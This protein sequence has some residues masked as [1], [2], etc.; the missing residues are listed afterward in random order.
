M[1]SL[2][3]R[4]C[5]AT[6]LLTLAT[7]ALA[8]RT[9]PAA[10]GAAGKQGQAAR[11]LNA[12]G[13]TGKTSP[14]GNGAHNANASGMTRPA[15]AAGN[16][17]LCPALKPS[18]SAALR[19][20]GAVI[21][22]NNFQG[23]LTDTQQSNLARAVEAL[24]KMNDEIRSGDKRQIDQAARVAVASFPGLQQLCQVRPGGPCLQHAGCKPITDL[25][26]N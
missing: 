20:S 12:P 23:G 9:A 10:A 26:S 2:S 7:P 5:I 3:T 1:K 13:V 17:A 25:A 11:P 18:I 8:Q 6:I 15:E 24:G 16:G 4:L 21:A 22:C 14:A 19:N